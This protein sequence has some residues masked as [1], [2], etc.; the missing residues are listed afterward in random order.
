MSWNIA[1][2][3]EL[4]KLKQL[5]VYLEQFDIVCLTETHTTITGTVN[6]PNFKL[7]EFPD[8]NCNY[9]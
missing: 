7:Y 9:E 2:K 8:K 3:Y 6:F 5:Q 1:G 4:L